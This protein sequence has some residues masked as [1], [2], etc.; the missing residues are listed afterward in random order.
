MGKIV[1][2]QAIFGLLAAENSPAKPIQFM[3]F[4][5]ALKTDILVDRVPTVA[6]HLRF[7]I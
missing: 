7:L 6:S 2:D 3:G 4:H 1:S 5:W